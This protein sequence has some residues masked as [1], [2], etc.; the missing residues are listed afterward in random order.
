VPFLFLEGE[1]KM[2]KIL[3]VASAAVLTLG[4]AACASEEAEEAPAEDSAMEAAPVDSAA[5]A[6]DSADS[7]VDSAA[8]ATDSAAEAVDSAAESAAE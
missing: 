5:S 6:V 8:E 3:A 1:M 2:K 4:L 7:A